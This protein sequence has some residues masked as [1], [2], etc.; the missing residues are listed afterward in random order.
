M[1]K[2]P[3]TEGHFEAKMALR[4]QPGNA[5]MSDDEANLI[6]EEREKIR[7]AKILGLTLASGG[8][9][10]SLQMGGQIPALGEDPPMLD[11]SSRF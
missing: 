2:Y 11:M 4:A 9:V 8:Q 5:G 10:P 3:E 6:V 1:E 7:A